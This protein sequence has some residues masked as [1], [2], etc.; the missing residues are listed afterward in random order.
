MVTGP[1]S[2]CLAIAA[3]TGIRPMPIYWKLA[4]YHHP[5]GL[6][7]RA[8]THHER[9]VRLAHKSLL[10]QDL[11]QMTGDSGISNIGR[12]FIQERFTTPSTHNRT[13]LVPYWCLSLVAG[14]IAHTNCVPHTTEVCK[15]Q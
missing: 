2:K 15:N 14:V 1:I 9:G 4:P 7:I 13:A 3:E 11:G 12:R 6:I 10:H 8:V 5:K